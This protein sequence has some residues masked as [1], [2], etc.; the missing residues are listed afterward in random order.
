MKQKKRRY[1]LATL[2][3]IAALVGVIR[4]AMPTRPTTPPVQQIQGEEITRVSTDTAEKKKPCD[5]CKER[6]ARRKEQIRNARERRQ[7][8]Q[9]A[10][11]SEASQ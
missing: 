1:L 10:A 4:F 9:Q 2:G 3:V 6:I 8:A 7:A 5:C 11:S